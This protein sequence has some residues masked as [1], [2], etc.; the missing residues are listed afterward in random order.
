ME[1]DE[2]EEEE[3]E[4]ECV[5]EEEEEEELGEISINDK[6]AYDEDGDIKTKSNV[7]LKKKKSRTPPPFTSNDYPTSSISDSDFLVGAYIY[8]YIYI[9]I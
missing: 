1:V 7:I 9:Y 3:E 8:I 2:E 6:D 4:E 5:E